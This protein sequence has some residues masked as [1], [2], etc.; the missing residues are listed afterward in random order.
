ML[1]P[2]AKSLFGAL[3]VLAISTSALEAQEVH[4]VKMVDISETEFAFQPAEITV[5]PGDVIRWEQTGVMPHNVEFREGPMA[6][7]M[8]DFLVTPGQTY[9]VTIAADMAAQSFKY[10]CTP[11]ELMGMVGTI[12]I[13]APTPVPFAPKK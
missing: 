5:K 12:T 8:S 3:A 9:E 13:A 1:R 6:G 11:H 10:L 7:T 4:V 2:F